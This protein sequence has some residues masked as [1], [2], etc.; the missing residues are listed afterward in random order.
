MR[1]WMILLICMLVMVSCT[2]Q[3]SEGEAVLYETGMFTIPDSTLR[4]E[5]HDIW[6]V[7]YYVNGDTLFTSEKYHFLS[8][9][10]SYNETNEMAFQHIEFFNKQQAANADGWY[11]IT[12]ADADIPYEPDTHLSGIVLRSYLGDKYDYKAYYHAHADAYLFNNTMEMAADRDRN[13]LTQQLRK[14]LP[15]ISQNNE[16]K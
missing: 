5:R 9:V 2:G 14:L 15:Y 16:Y 1:Y 13:E 7:K 8:L 12:L 3:Q 10:Y 11:Q 4:G 6:K